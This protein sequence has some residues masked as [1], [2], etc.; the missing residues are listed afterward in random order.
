MRW[1]ETNIIKRITIKKMIWVELI[2]KN[3]KNCLGRRHRQLIR[4]LHT[5]EKHMFLS[6]RRNEVS[7][8]KRNTDH[9]QSPKCTSFRK[10]IWQEK[11]RQEAQSV[12][13]TPYMYTYIC[14]CI[15]YNECVCVC[16][17]NGYGYVCRHYVV[18]WCMCNYEIRS[19]RNYG[20]ATSC[21][22]C[23]CL[24]TPKLH[25]IRHEGCDAL[26]HLDPEPTCVRI[27]QPCRVTHCISAYLSLL[28][29]GQADIL[30]LWPDLCVCGIVPASPFQRFAR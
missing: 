22:G 8:A 29:K 16:L 2:E 25:D 12:R 17:Q 10:L 7:A 15:S 3:T 9:C 19:V 11:N 5:R 20:R 18:L 13:N 6:T 4:H 24:N 23:P 30:R 28:S 21:R 26:A 1:I 14:I 27:C